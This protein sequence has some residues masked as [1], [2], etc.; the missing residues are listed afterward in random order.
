MY[1]CVPFYSIQYPPKFQLVAKLLI[2]TFHIL[3]AYDT[4]LSIYIYMYVS[5]IMYPQDPPD[6][7][8]ITPCTPKYLDT[9]SIVPPA[10]HP[11]PSHLGKL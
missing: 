5:N 8:H 11:F 7:L 4:P 6:I 2:I 10:F 9:M 3:I 1:L